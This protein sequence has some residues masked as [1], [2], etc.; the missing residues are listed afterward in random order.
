MDLIRYNSL[1]R[2]ADVVLDWHDY[3]I[4]T[5]LDIM[6]NKQA[7]T[8]LPSIASYDT[9]FIKPELLASHELIHQL[10][11]INVP[12]NLLSGSSD[13]TIPHNILDFIQKNKNMMTWSGQNLIKFNER[14][15]Q[16]PVGFQEL[17]WG[18]PN[19]YV[20]FPEPVPKIIPIV[21]TPIS[22]G[23]NKEARHQI[24][25]VAGKNILNIQHRLDYISFMDLMNAS[26][27][28]ISPPG[29]GV[30]CHRTMESIKV[31]SRP[32]VIRSILDDLH[33]EMGCAI[34]D[35]WLEVGN[36]DLAIPV[37]M[38]KKYTTFEYWKQRIQAHQ[39]LFKI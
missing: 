6:H 29:N 35:N 31:N 8:S 9:I 26:R 19:S 17:G 33:T 28:S 32:I 39:E 20:K 30:D 13:I 24:E 7:H 14:F 34:V 36:I 4:Q 22:V 15:L 5:G 25:N 10:A 18:R 16:I 2:L 37:N 38:D 3:Y 21:L 12:F 1:T 23:N 11:N 27:Y